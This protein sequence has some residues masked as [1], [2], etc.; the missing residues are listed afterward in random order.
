MKKMTTLAILGLIGCSGATTANETQSP[1]DRPNPPAAQDP[2]KPGSPPATQAPAASADAATNLARL[3]GLNVIE[4]GDLIVTSE[5]ANCYFTSAENVLSNICDRNSD[6]FRTAKV[7][8][9]K[10][11]AAFT[12][13]VI[14]AAEKPPASTG[15]TAEEK[16]ANISKLARLRI[17][18][19]DGLIE[20]QPKNNP[21]CYNL[22]CEEDKK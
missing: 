21:H 6:E 10:R 20:E 14:K 15:M 13:T 4:F 9:E 7:E 8:A 17:V 12:D 2:A 5:T 3:R 1:A 19:V 22:P 16:Q 11:L 18:R